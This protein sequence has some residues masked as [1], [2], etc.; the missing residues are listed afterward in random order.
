GAEG[1]RRRRRAS[2]GRHTG[3][4][5]DRCRVRRQR[6]RRRSRR[7][8]DG[9]AGAA[10]TCP[11][12]RADAAARR[13]RVGR[14]APPAIHPRRPDERGPL[15]ASDDRRCLS[16]QAVRPR[17]APRDG[18]RGPCGPRPPGAAAEVGRAPR[19]ARGERRAPG[20]WA[21]RV[22]ARGAAPAERCPRR[23]LPGG[24]AV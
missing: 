1:A 24:V 6:C 8:R 15:A 11:Q 16:R 21:G 7:A 4:D 14:A 3:R 23:L 2:T 12:R 18:G 22:V 5:P 9:G 10:G 17:R 13:H 19:G 20:E